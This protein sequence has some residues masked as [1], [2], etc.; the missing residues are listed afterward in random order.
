MFRMSIGHHICESGALKV[1][2]FQDFRRTRARQ[3]TEVGKPP[4]EVEG[5]RPNLVWPL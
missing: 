4:G 1:L 3:A 5:E 2:P